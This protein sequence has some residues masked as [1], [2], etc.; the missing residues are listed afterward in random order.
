MF[1]H[2]SNIAKVQHDNKTYKLWGASQHAQYLICGS[3]LLYH[4]EQEVRR[5]LNFFLCLRY[6]VTVATMGLRQYNATLVKQM[7][8]MRQTNMSFT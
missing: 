7:K 5:E 6:V 2:I 8:S 3:D 4:L 1:G